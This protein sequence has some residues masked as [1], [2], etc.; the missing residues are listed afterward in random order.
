M[1]WSPIGIKPSHPC[2]QREMVAFWCPPS[3]FLPRLG[4][5]PTSPA[6]PVASAVLTMTWDLYPRFSPHQ[7]SWNW[8]GKEKGLFG[9]FPSE[10]VQVWICEGQFGERDHKPWEYA[11]LPSWL[12]KSWNFS[13]GNLWDGNA[14]LNVTKVKGKKKPNIT[15][16]SEYYSLF[17]IVNTITWIE[18]WYSPKI[19]FPDFA[20]IKMR[21]G[22]WKN[23][24]PILK[25]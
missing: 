13:W 9:C 12:S 17:I 24:F 22:T 19:H 5:A 6:N 8:W 11:Y 10:L 2:F 3:I 15:V 7:A 21:V 18:W 20:S 23:L 1:L 14:T 4:A 25:K 16:N